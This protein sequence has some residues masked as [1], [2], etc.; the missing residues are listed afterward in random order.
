MSTGSL[1][2]PTEALRRAVA[3]LATQG[4]WTAPL[5]EEACLRFDVAPTDEEFLLREM[6]RQ[7]AER[8]AQKPV[9]K[10]TPKA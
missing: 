1:L 6:H 9:S 5:V 7:S 10:E 4:G 3:W 8:A 2:P